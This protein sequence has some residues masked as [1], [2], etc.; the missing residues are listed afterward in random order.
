MR[1]YLLGMCRPASLACSA[2]ACRAIEVIAAH[3]SA[4]QQGKEVSAMQERRILCDICGNTWGTTTNIANAGQLSAEGI[5]ASVSKSYADPTYSGTLTISVSSNVASGTYTVKLNATGD[6]P[7]SNTAT[8]S[9][10]VPAQPASTT[11]ASTIPASTSIAPTVSVAPTTVAPTTVAP[12][13][14]TSGTHAANYAGY[15][16]AAMV[17]IVV[18]A[19]AVF[20]LVSRRK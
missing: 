18:I 4:L 3:P 1:T 10:F 12:T 13:T 8:V 7:S 14:G 5:T 9:V 11:T 19:V 6:D 20:F 17:V 15:E 16:I 2:Y